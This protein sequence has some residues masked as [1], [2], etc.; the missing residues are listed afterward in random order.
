MADSARQA[1]RF[2]VLERLGLGAA[3][4]RKL[5]DFDKPLA[6]QMLSG[7]LVARHVGQAIAE[8][9]SAENFGGA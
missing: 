4:G 8:P 1:E 6:A 2:V 3:E 7:V 5:A 9:W